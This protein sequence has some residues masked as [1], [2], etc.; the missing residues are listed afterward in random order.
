MRNRI[1]APGHGRAAPLR[2]RSPPARAP[3]R[4]RRSCSALAAALTEPLGE[5]LARAAPAPALTSAAR[6]AWRSSRSTGAR[7][8]SARRSSSAVV[9]VGSPGRARPA[10]GDRRLEARTEG[11]PASPRAGPLGAPDGSSQPGRRQRAAAHLVLASGRTASAAAARRPGRR[12]GA[13][14][15]AAALVASVKR[16]AAGA[17][18]RP[19][20]STHLV[21]GLE[22]L[23]GRSWRWTALATALTVRSHRRFAWRCSGRIGPGPLRGAAPSL[24]RRSTRPMRSSCCGEPRLQGGNL[25]LGSR[26]EARRTTGP[27]VSGHRSPP[28]RRAPCRRPGFRG[29]SP[30]VLCLVPS[31][32]SLGLH[33]AGP[34]ERLPKMRNLRQF[35]RPCQLPVEVY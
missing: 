12:A 21:Y 20:R 29:R 25:S 31:A 6:P 13:R 16:L 26:P 14:S 27:R 22:R 7:S 9:R 17:A 5:L 10:R 19:A 23:R 4:S 33:P 34:T 24:R 32:S 11:H 8:G 1:A 2:V 35:A 28:P 15:I 18:L 3:A 30:P